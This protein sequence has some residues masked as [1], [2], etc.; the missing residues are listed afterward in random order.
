VK[1]ARGEIAEFNMSAKDLEEFGKQAKE[2]INKHVAD[3]QQFGLTTSPEAR[4]YV[5]MIIERIFPTMQVLSNLEIARGMDVQ[6]IGSI[7]E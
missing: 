2:T 3:R 1:D 5:R 7:G 4:K 6:V